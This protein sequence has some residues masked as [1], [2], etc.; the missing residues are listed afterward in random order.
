MGSLKSKQSPS[1]GRKSSG[2]GPGERASP[3]PTVTAFMTGGG[4]PAQTQHIPQGWRAGM[5]PAAIKHHFC[6]LQQER[7][8]GSNSMCLVLRADFSPGSFSSSQ[9]NCYAV[10]IHLCCPYLAAA[11]ERLQRMEN[12]PI[13]KTS[14]VWP[15][16]YISTIAVP[17]LS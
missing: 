3:L 13:C 17:E 4:A 9:K 1:F 2:Q 15:A 10:D 14:R 11:C 16:S 8:S 5:G 7:M 6:I 12:I